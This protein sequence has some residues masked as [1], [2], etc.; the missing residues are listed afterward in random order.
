[1]LKRPM[2]PSDNGVMWL[3]K[4]R[5]EKEQITDARSAFDTF[6]AEAVSAAP[7]QAIALATDF[8]ENP[9]IAALPEKELLTRSRDA[10]R[11]YCNTILADDRLTAEEEMAFRSVAAAL[12]VDQATFTRDHHEIFCHFLI[13][14]LNDGR[15]EPLPDPDM[16]VKKDEAVYLQLNGAAMLKE[17]AIREWQ[18]GSRGVSFRIAK[19]VSYR[20]GNTRGRSVVVGTELQVEDTG[21]LF[22][23]SHRIV[24]TG[25]RKSLEIPLAKLL[26][27]DVYSDAIIF[28]ASNRRNA[29]MFQ[30]G[31]S[32]GHVVAATV[33][34][35]A[36]RL[37]A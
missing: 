36:Q 25:M 22:V 8:R 20:V 12:G 11:A 10:F 31:A 27:L 24:F 21:T 29:P 35:S 33:N 14:K 19:G 16:L 13:A 4:S 28:H 9:T 17:V 3:L 32:M 30:V 15:L 23:T 7:Q 2:R 37:N 1:M 5:E 6:V 34:A 18:A 26:D